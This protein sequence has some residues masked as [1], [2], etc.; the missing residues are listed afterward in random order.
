M[1][2]FHSQNLLPAEQCIEALI[3]AGGNVHLA[4]ERLFGPGANGPAMLTASIAQDPLALESLNAQLRTLT[5]LQAFDALHEARVLLPSVLAELEPKDF[6]NY[7]LKLVQSMREFT[8]PSDAPTSPGDALA[9]LINLLPP[10][11]RRAFMVLVDTVPSAS[12]GE[13][14]LGDGS[15]ATESHELERTEDAA[16]SSPNDVQRTDPESGREAA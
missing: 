13:L 6:A 7:Y 5:T 12:D 3:I 16:S 9:R 2:N 11:A 8:E 14:A 4:A 10:D 1:S 15:G